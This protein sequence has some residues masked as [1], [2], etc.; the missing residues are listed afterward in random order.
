M[1]DSEISRLL[2]DL[3]R[4]E[5]AAFARLYDHR[6]GRMLGVAKAL[7][8]SAADA[9]DVVQDVFVALVRGR[10]GLTT[11]RDLDAYLFRSVRRAAWRCIE[12]RDRAPGELTAEP[13]AS[14][15]LVDGL[16]SRDGTEKRDD[17]LARAR[18]SLPA[19]QR[20]VLALKVEGE[21]TFAEIGKMV[22]VSTST[23]ASRYRYALERLRDRLATRQG[24]KASEAGT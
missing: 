21:M 24:T 3:A 18:Q 13:V 5:A 12:R 4:G 11:V 16:V 17:A 15:D 10:R 20:E 2:G 1:S 22:G 19:E 23:A 6:G 8:G 9:E 14:P 7:V